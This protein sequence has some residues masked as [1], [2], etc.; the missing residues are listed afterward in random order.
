[1][2]RATYVGGRRRAAPPCSP[3]LRLTGRGCGCG[4][5]RC[6]GRTWRGGGVGRAGAAARWRWCVAALAVRRRRRSGV[7]TRL[8]TR[9]GADVAFTPLGCIASFDGPALRSTGTIQQ[10]RRG[11]AVG[12]RRHVRGGRCRSRRRNDVGRI[13]KNPATRVVAW[14]II[15]AS[16]TARIDRNQRPARHCDI[17]AAGHR[18]VEA[19]LHAPSRI[20]YDERP[21]RHHIVRH[22][23]ARVLRQSPWID[24]VRTNRTP[25]AE[26][27]AR[28]D[29]PRPPRIVVGPIGRVIP[30]MPREPD[31]GATVPPERAPTHIS[32]NERPTH[33]CRTPDPVGNPVPRR[34]RETPSAVMMRRPRPRIMANPGQA[35]PRVR[36]RPCVVRPPIGA[37]RGK[38]DVAVRRDRVP[39][40]IAV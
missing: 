38:P 34:A 4:G 40:A 13:S 26:A 7:A 31:G 6:W 19:G 1:M 24:R 15:T 14:N 39:S 35:V 30:R 3:P 18:R 17:R 10:R 16:F 32:R 37:H 25:I 22:H 28:Y 5:R 33:P 12:A 23:A 21:A 29:G 9:A 20:R 2:R 11:C 36:P 27:G 8:G